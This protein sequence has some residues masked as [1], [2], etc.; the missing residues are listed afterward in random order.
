MAESNMEL[1]RRAYEILEAKAGGDGLKKTVNTFIIGLICL[2]VVAQI[3]E[4]VHSVKVLAPGVFILI[5]VVSV[6]IFSVE[7]VLRLWSCVED[8]RYGKPVRGR[9]RFAATPMALIDL[10]AI[11][12]FYLPFMGIDLRA[13]RIARLMRIFRLAKLGRYSTSLQ[14]LQRVIK[15]KKE[16]LADTVFILLVLLV[17]ASSLMYLAE[18]KVQPDKFSSIPAAMWWAVSTLTTVGYGDICPI[19]T[20]GKML[21]SVIAVLGIG[22]FA[23]P[24]GILGA[25]FVEEREQQKKHLHCPHCGKE[26]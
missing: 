22:M 25:G 11:L 14:I 26:M 24:T 17:M 1:R 4:S 2:N 5:E 13:M 12:P 10:I 3:F 21:A 9:L 16:Q 6:L 15:A 20:A 8:A 19:T 23:L 7:Y 18:N